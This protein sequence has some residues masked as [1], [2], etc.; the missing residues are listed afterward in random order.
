MSTI[1]HTAGPGL[2]LLLLAVALSGHAPPVRAARAASTHVVTLR[3]IAFHP[4]RLTIAR[5]SSVRFV[6]KDPGV[7][8]N[9]TSRGPDRFR[10]AGSRKIGAY[11]VRLTRR[12][13]YR[14]VCTIHFGMKGTIVVR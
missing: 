6:W 10:S 5:A 14:Y 13:T 12:G 11:T 7:T 4:A 1:G 3:G 2:G 8:H 9:V